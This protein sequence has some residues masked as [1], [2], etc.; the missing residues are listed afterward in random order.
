M[1]FNLSENLTVNGLWC[2]CLGNILSF[3]F[4]LHIPRFFGVTEVSGFRSSLLAACYSV[5]S[6]PITWKRRNHRRT[7]VA[8][9]G[10][11]FITPVMARWANLCNF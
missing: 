3:G 4:V 5:R 2:A 6:L 7:S 9:V 8:A 1:P 11:V 10:V